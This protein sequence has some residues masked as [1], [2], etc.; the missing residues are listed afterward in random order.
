VKRERVLF[1]GGPLDGAIAE[2]HPECSRLGFAVYSEGDGDNEVWWGYYA[3][4]TRDG[5]R[6]FRPGKPKQ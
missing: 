3:H 2:L 6:V 4:E 5:F 1:L